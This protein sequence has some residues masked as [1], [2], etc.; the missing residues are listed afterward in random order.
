MARPGLE[1]LAELLE[2]YCDPTAKKYAVNGNALGETG[3]TTRVRSIV[4]LDTLIQGLLSPREYERRSQQFFET[5][6]PILRMAKMSWLTEF[7]R[8][9]DQSRTG[10]IENL[11]VRLFHERFQGEHQIPYEDRRKEAELFE[12]LDHGYAA[13]DVRRFRNKAW[14]HLDLAHNLQPPTDNNGDIHAMTVLLLAW[15]QFV[16]TFMF[17]CEPRYVTVGAAQAANGFLKEFRHMMVSA[18]RARR[19]KYSRSKDTVERD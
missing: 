17:E 9:M 18:R 5:Y 16:G 1:H 3:L 13:H 7:L 6:G 19:A 4:Y 2:G 8:V 10:A 11:T 12:A 14:F 15:Y